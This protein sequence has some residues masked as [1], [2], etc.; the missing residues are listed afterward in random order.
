MPKYERLDDQSVFPNLC[1]NTSDIAPAH[2]AGNWEEFL[3]YFD[4]PDAITR[5]AV[6]KASIAASKFADDAVYGEVLT[7]YPLKRG[8][9]NVDLPKLAAKRKAEP[10]IGM[11]CK[12]KEWTDVNDPCCGSGVAFEGSIEY[13]DE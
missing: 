5:M 2:V 4:T 10:R 11:C 1:S 12:C 13:A 7:V 3:A 6:C 9:M 8:A